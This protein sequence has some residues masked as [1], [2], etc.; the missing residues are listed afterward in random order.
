M[1]MSLR[2]SSPLAGEG[3]RLFRGKDDRLTAFAHGDGGVLRWTQLRPGGAEWEG[4]EFFP[5]PSLSHLSVTRGADGFLHLVGRRVSPDGSSV[6]VV[7]ATQYQTGRPLTQWRSLGNPYKDPSRAQRV[8]SPGVAVSGTG[9]VHVFLANDGGAVT[10]RKEDAKGRWQAWSSLNG[11]MAQDGMV[12]VASVSGC[13][14]LLVPASNRRAMRWSQ[15]E[16]QGELERRPNIPMSPDPGTLVG[17]ETAP[18][19]ITYF[20]SDS[21]AGGL[22]AHRPGEW[23]IPVGGGQVEGRPAALRAVLD[24]YDCTV[25]AY[26]SPDDTVMIA[27]CA[28]ENEASGLWWSA[29]AERCAAPPALACDAYGRVVLATIDGS[30]ALRVAVQAAEPG[31]VIAP[32]V[33]V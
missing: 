32:S 8:T 25:L 21:A 2:S 31:L 16:P 10:M 12:A 30:G 24:G 14:E 11:Q 9:S 15:V 22:M 26:R 18:E 13:I 33:R 29:T 23:V 20:W 3:P 1:T 19:R 5:A 17:L 4:P 28:T 27:A 7:Q 6:T